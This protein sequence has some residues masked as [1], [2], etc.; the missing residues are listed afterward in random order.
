M[1]GE[2]YDSRGVRLGLG[3]HVVYTQAETRSRPFPDRMRDFG[4]AGPDNWTGVVI[5]LQPLQ[6]LPDD[7][8]LRQ[9]AKI[10]FRLA[11]EMPYFGLNSY[12]LTRLD[13]PPA[14]G[15][16]GEPYV[17]VANL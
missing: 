9:V 16:L 2:K 5:R 11:G 10:D 6:I 13:G 8:A 1:A 15:L 7:E 14:V 3:D 4:Y 12:R 17:V